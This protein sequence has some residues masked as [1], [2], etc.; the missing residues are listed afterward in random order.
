MDVNLSY[1]I[2]F[3]VI[4]VHFHSCLGIHYFH[5]WIYLMYHTLIHHI[6]LITIMYGFMRGRDSLPIKAKG[7]APIFFCSLSLVLLSS[8]YYVIVFTIK[9]LL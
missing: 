3:L 9:N 1:V 8:N 5:F 4:F 7:K 2:S 6:S